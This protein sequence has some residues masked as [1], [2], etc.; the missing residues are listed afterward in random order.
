MRARTILLTLVACCAG[1]VV[2]FAAGPEMGKWKLN[3]AK[4]QIA[5]GAPKLTMV[6]YEAAGDSVKITVDGVDAAG[7]PTHSSWT[8]K[9]DGKDY[10]VTGDTT[11]DTRSYTKVDERTLTFTSK[12]GGKAVNSGRAVIAADGKTRKV[13][14]SG[15][16][17]A[18]KKITSTAE[19]DKQ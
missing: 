19:Y 4:S 12:K 16:D 13:T 6:A 9:Y 14:L 7:K 17:S 8:G 10:P 2:C 5:A 18:G 3:E 15:T 1:T 11:S